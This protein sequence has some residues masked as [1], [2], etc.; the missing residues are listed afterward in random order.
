MSRALTIEEILKRRRQSIEHNKA[1]NGCLISPGI[2]A[3]NGKP[4]VML[5]NLENGRIVERPGLGVFA[6]DS[7]YAAKLADTKNCRSTITK[8]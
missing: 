3:E 7:E 1:P 6:V 5:Q 2:G 8:R 4:I